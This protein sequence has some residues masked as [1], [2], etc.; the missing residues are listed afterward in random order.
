MAELDTAIAHNCAAL[1]IPLHA[2]GIPVA[3]LQ[4][5]LMRLFPESPKY[6]LLYKKNEIEARR[7][8][9]F[10]QPN[11]TDQEVIV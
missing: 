4:I 8:L 5:A 10:F 7:A 1:W 9:E 2:I 3:L 6:L 11:I